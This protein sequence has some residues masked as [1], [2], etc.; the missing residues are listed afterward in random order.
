MFQLL[1]MDLDGT[2]ADFDSPIQSETVELLR[3][4]QKEGVRIVVASGKPACYVSA[5]VRQT[6]LENVILIGDNGGVIYFDHRFP[7]SN[8]IVMEMTSAAAE[9]MKKVKSAILA[10]YGNKIWIQ[11]NQVT[12]SLLVGKA[13]L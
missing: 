10:E 9:E 4:L 2:L 11:P 5:L 8:P 13:I 3:Q 12:L 7:P 6:G 1:V